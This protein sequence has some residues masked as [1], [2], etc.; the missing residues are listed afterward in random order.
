[1]F[2]A[3]QLQGEGPFD[4]TELTFAKIVVTHVAIALDRRGKGEADEEGRYRFLSDFTSA[5]LE[6][7]TTGSVLSAAVQLA[8]P[9]MA[10]VCFADEIAEDDSLSRVEPGF[11]NEGHQT[12]L[13]AL[14]GNASSWATRE[15]Q[16]RVASL[17]TS[18]ICDDMSNDEWMDPFSALRL[19]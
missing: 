19:Q 8:A 1:A 13:S 5:L 4:E 12:L 17:G 18:V 11:A 14:M 2:G 6:L 3:V 10:D 9:H 7:R 16:A 15:P